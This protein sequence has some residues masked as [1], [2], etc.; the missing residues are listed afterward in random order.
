MS[1]EGVS[2]LGLGE[3]T[4]EGEGSSAFG[5]LGA[6]VLL[7]FFTPGF[8]EI[9]LGFGGGSMSCFLGGGVGIFS[10]LTFFGRGRGGGVTTGVLGVSVE[11]GGREA[12]G[13]EGGAGGV[14]GG[15]GRR[16]GGRGR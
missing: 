7:T 16:E 2:E 5:F 12:G 9:L 1:K 13:V 14:A 6:M 11:G 4:G 10:T 8:S 15:G 3:G